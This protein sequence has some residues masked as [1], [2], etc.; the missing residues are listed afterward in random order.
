MSIMCVKNPVVGNV[1]SYV[2][3]KLNISVGPGTVTSNAKQSA[4]VEDVPPVFEVMSKDVSGEGS[5][6]ER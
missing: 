6:G 5:G 1:S 2:N 3:V 4:R